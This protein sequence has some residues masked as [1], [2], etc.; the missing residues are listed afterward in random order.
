MKYA[1]LMESAKQGASR[2]SGGRVSKFFDCL[3]AKVSLECPS[4]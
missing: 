2:A 1:V 3:S 4:P